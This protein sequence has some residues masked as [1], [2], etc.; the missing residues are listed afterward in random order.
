MRE[1]LLSLNNREIAFGIWF[2]FIFLISLICSKSVRRFTLGFFKIFLGK[3][4]F[5]ILIAFSFIGFELLL[6]MKIGYWEKSFLK[7][8]LIW[9]STVAF[10][11]LYNFE[12]FKEISYFKK[13]IKDNFKVILLLEFISNSFSFSFTTELILF[14]IVGILALI[15]GVLEAKVEDVLG[16]PELTRTKIK[17][18]LYLLLNIYIITVIVFSLK[19]AYFNL[20]E[21]I[22]LS[23]LK[24]F[25]LPIIMTMLFLPFMYLLVLK[26]SYRELFFRIDLFIV[27]KQ[28]ASQIKRFV[29]HMVNLSLSKL[30][31]LNK[32]INYV[33]LIELSDRRKY[34]SKLIS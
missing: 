25:L 21:L 24:L 27:D 18:T 28:Q 19:M 17:K 15:L 33:K 6:L 3:A 5:T 12:K 16:I 8:L 7:D 29:F 23:N 32:K 2:L 10:I 20:N 4:L 1:I 11:Y 22:T 26:E 13:A 14:P 30:V 31:S 9:I 34:I